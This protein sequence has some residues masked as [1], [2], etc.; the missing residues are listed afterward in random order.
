MKRIEFTITGEDGKS[1]NEPGFVEDCSELPIAVMRAV[2]DFIEAHDGN[3][4]LPITIQIRSS[5]GTSTC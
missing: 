5:S 1:L 4:H 2:E 3:P